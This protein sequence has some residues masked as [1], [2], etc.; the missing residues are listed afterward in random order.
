MDDEI[1]P[2]PLRRDLGENVVETFRILDIGGKNEFRAELFQ[3]RNGAAAERLALIGAGEF[4]ALLARRARDALCERAV[5]GHAQDQPA[6]ARHQP[7]RCIHRVFS[8][9]AGKD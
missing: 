7:C 5:V 6:L 8:D 9:S 3:Q 4:G 1:E 2:A